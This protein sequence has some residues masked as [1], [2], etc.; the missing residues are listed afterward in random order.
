MKSIRTRV[1]L[2]TTLA[3]VAGSSAGCSVMQTSGRWTRESGESMEAYSK[4]NEGVWASLAGYGGRF[5]KSVGGSMESMAGGG[6]AAAN[7][8]ASSAASPAPASTAAQ[9]SSVQYA[10][11][12]P[13]ATTAAPAGAAVAHDASMISRAQARLLELGYRIGTA[14][15]ILGPKTKGALRQYQRAN[16]LSE[17]GAL[18]HATLVALGLG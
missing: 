12:A 10:A 6:S 1:A 16:G 18:D 9:G 13:T 7:D 8:A 14:D 15:G 11:V 5:N 4:S 2:Y 3:L 17:T